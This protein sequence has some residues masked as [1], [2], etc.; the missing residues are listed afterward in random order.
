MPSTMAGIVR[1]PIFDRHR[2]PISA[3]PEIGGVAERQHAGIAEQEIERHRRQAEYDDAAAEFGI[4]ADRGQPVRHR[5]QQQPD[6]DIRCLRCADGGS[7][8]LP[9]SPRRPR[10]R[11]SSTSAIMT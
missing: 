4:A 2:G 7:L 9:S 10:G 11:I 5:Q 3:E 6:D 1:D 8:N